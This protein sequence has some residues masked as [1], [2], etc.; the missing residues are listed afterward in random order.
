MWVWSADA[1]G[2]PKPSDQSAEH[3]IAVDRCAREIAAFLKPSHAARARQLNAKPFGTRGN[4]IA[5]P[6][7]DLGATNRAS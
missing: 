3:G 6:F 2:N 5:I 4:V 7:L 1:A